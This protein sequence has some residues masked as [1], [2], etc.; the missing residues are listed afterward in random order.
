[1]KTKKEILYSWEE[2][3]HDM[4]QVVIPI[5]DKK[6]H[7]F[8]G[9]WGP[10]VGGLVPATILRHALDLPYLISPQ[11]P[12][13]LIVDDIADSGK[14]LCHWEKNPI[15]TLFYFRKSI[16]TP[17]LWVR[18]KKSEDEWIVFPWEKHSS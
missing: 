15:V 12:Q 1:M 4:Y 10:P 5:L 8:D 3:L 7:L 17:M 13:T 6:K 14:S 2:F 11:S 18:E 9:V 16:V